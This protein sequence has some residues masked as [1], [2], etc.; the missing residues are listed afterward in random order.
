MGQTAT[1]IPQAM[2][3]FSST[4]IVFQGNLPC[5]S[6]ILLCPACC[7]NNSRR[8][9]LVG[10]GPAKFRLSRVPFDFSEADLSTACRP[11]P[12]SCFPGRA[13]LEK[14][15]RRLNPVSFTCFICLSSNR[16]TNPVN[17]RLCS[18]ALNLVSAFSNRVPP[19]ANR[20]WEQ[21]LSVPNIH[22]AF[23]R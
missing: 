3:F 15:A 23:G 13:T 19:R 16:S 14:N 5:G 1:Q 20:H 4:F 9:S 11:G 21:S 6:E 7:L 17:P 8:D 10:D 22:A 2:Q 18:H 12:D